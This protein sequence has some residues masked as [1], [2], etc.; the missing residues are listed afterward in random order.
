MKKAVFKLLLK[1]PVFVICDG[2]GLN[3]SSTFTS[4]KRMRDLRKSLTH[5]K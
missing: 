5:S 3:Y 2:I 4:E 1:G